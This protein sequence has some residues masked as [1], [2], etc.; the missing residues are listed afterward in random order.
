MDP[1][2]ER[3]KVILKEYPQL[4]TLFGNTPSTAF[5]VFF[6]VAL[7]I[8][9]A[10][11]LVEAPWWVIILVAYC[12]GA[13][14]NHGIWALVHELTHDLV[15]KNPS[16]NKLLLLVANFPLFFPSTIG[17]RKY[18]MFHHRHQGDVNFDA[19][20]PAEF[21]KSFVGKSTFRKSI[22]LLFYF[23]FQ[24]VR[25]TYVKKIHLW[26]AWVVANGV[27]QVCFLFTLWY[28]AG[29]FALLYLLFSAGFSIGLHPVGARWIQEHYLIKQDQETYS[30]YGPLNLLSYNVG[31]H[32][33]HHDFMTVPWSRLRKVRKIAAPYY[34]N[35]YF[36]RSWTALLFKF[37]FDP[38]LNLE[39][40]RTR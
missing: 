18:H 7:Q 21:E 16:L 12:V 39:S 26:D 6:S 15:F 2:K 5:F 13:F 17:F 19:D 37:L 14:I 30:Y 8:A 36:H 23:V 9:I 27:S 33:E 11:L 1:H 35:L 22:W 31:Y 20:L 32:N 40:R 38:N 4:K 24:T 29:P 10:C 3:T 25:I 34:D 28:F